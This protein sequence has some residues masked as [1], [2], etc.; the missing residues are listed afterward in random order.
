MQQLL[1]LLVL[2]DFLALCELC[3]VWLPILRW[4]SAAAAAAA[5]ISSAVTTSIWI[6]LSKHE[7]THP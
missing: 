2:Q 1:L 5:G 7:Q 6:Q 4:H 3:K